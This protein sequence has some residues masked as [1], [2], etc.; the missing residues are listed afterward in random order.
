MIESICERV[1]LSTISVAMLY[2]VL[3]QNQESDIP[4]EQQL[5]SIYED[6]EEEI[7]A[8]FSDEILKRKI[9]D[10][11]SDCLS[12]MNPI[13]FELGMQAGAKLSQKL[14]SEVT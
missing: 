1:D 8:L 12:K 6:F 9:Q 10:L 14:L 7:E 4:R 5:K 13:Y 3:P 2:G 11:F